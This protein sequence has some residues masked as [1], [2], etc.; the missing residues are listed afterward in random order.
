MY[1]CSL[2]SVLFSVVVNVIGTLSSIWET[3]TY[4]MVREGRKEEQ[5][6]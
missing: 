6:C 4:G 5:E 1:L 3:G 2:S